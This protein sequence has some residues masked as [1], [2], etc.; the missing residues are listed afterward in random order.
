MAIVTDA[1]TTGMASSLHLREAQED[2]FQARTNL[3]E[4]LYEARIMETELLRLSGELVK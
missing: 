2:L 3:V 1:F 4:A